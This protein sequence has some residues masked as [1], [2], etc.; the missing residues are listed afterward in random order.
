MIYTDYN[1][2]RVS[3]KTLANGKWQIEFT[4]VDQGIFALLEL[5]YHA[6]QK[7][8]YYVNDLNQDV[9]EKNVRKK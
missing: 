7:A 2:N 1:G 4:V 3:G 8:E 5:F 9:V 6:A